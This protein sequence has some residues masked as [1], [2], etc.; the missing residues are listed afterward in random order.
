MVRLLLDREKVYDPVLRSIHAWNALAI[1]LLLLGGRA[2]EWLGY[3]PEA[4]SLWRFHVWV[5][6]GLTLGLIA[7]LAWGLVGPPHAR[8]AALWQPHAWWQAL[9]S[10]KLFAEPE[11][12]SHHAP[13]AA[14]YL[15]LYLLL[16]A[17]AA[18]GLALAAI[19]QGRGPLYLWLGHDVTLKHLFREPHAWMENAVLAFVVVHIAALVVHEGRHGVPL[20]QAMVSGF[21][22]RK[23]DKEEA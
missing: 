19:D 13:A 8:I 6:Y 9:R 18:T 10:G 15:V 5:G 21:Q 1:V 14:V 17:M 7:R 22:Y 23:A 3:T 12:W 4:A 2:G 11:G 20:A 16:F